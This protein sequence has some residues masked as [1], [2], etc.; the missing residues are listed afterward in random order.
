M[1]PEIGRLENLEHLRLIKTM[2]KTLPS[3]IG[4]LKRLKTLILSG[5]KLEDLPPEISGLEQCET[6]G[7]VITPLAKNKGRVEE[8]RK[9]LPPGCELAAEKGN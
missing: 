6:I 4:K 2:I 7:I 1:P 5:S 3:E 9:I 8:L